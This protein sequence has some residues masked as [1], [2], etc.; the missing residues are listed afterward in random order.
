MARALFLLER[1]IRVQDTD[2][3][4]V[5]QLPG[6]GVILQDIAR[7][8]N[9]AFVIQIKSASISTRQVQKFAKDVLLMSTAMTHRV[10][11]EEGK[12]YKKKKKKKKGDRACRLFFGV[13]NPVD[14]ALRILEVCG[15][16]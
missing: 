4:N 6:Q 2:F 15:S 1:I 11:G 12:K 10:D 3:G 7:C 9:M 14:S 8:A 13:L 16:E 5:S